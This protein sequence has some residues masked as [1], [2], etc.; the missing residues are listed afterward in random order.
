MAIDEE[1]EPQ[2]D[3]IGVAVEPREELSLGLLREARLPELDIAQ[4]KCR[5]VP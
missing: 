1:R 5:V 3:N 4:S 2:R